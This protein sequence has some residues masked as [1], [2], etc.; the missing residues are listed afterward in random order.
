VPLD[1]GFGSAEQRSSRPGPAI[2]E[3]I[4]EPEIHPKSSGDP[5]SAGVRASLTPPG[6]RS[7]SR[8]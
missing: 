3:P 6:G 7:D 4:I 1:P 8:Y 2:D 5:E